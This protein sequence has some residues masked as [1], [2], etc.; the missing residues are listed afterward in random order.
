[1][2]WFGSVLC[3]DL[4]GCGLI[5]LV[6]LL[7]PCWHLD[8]TFFGEDAFRDFFPKIHDGIGELIDMNVFNGHLSVIDK[9]GWDSV[10]SGI[11]SREELG[12]FQLKSFE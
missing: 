9:I 1:M 12:T 6:C 4:L 3:V 10:T 11:L 5:L 8:F 2:Q 7:K